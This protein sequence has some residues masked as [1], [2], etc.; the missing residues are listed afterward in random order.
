MKNTVLLTSIV[1]LT[2][3]IGCA[4]QESNSDQVSETPENIETRLGEDLVITL[5][6]NPTTGYS[7]RLSEPLPGI[8]E[9]VGKEFKPAENME[10][11]AGAGGIEE[12]TLKSIEKGRAAVSFEYVR[13]WEKDKP[14]VKRRTFLITSK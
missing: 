3:F 4:K 13:P 2:I 1:G 6:S 8:L 14:P 11:I 12:W 7:W 5:E 9:L 10:N